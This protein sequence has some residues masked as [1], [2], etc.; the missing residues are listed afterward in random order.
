M[1]PDVIYSRRHLI[2]PCKNIVPSVLLPKGNI[3]SSGR[4][5]STKSQAAMA[6]LYAGKTFKRHILSQVVGVESG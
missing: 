1:N 5:F 3:L 6:A 2:D 4:E